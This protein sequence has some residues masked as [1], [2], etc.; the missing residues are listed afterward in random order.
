MN[1]RNQIHA[2]FVTLFLIIGLCL[3][4]VPASSVT[5]NLSELWTAS[6]SAETAGNYDEA[7]KQAVQWREAG[8]NKY[9]AALRDGW[10]N[11][12]KKDYPKA[13]ASYEEA[14]RLSTASITPLTG[15]LATAQA[16]ESPENVRAAADRILKLEPT[17]Y[18][19]LMAL[20]YSHFMEK[21]YM[22]ALSL[23]R[24]VVASYPENTDALS[25]AAWSAFYFG[26]KRDA[27]KWFQLIASIN[28]DYPWAKRGLELC[29]GSF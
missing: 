4:V 3:T 16:M 24:R 17:N 21:D 19:A 2:V 6:V 20:A 27:L 12:L 8:G 1:L 15:L 28:P 26:E 23:Y 11:Y 29:N 22:K 10:L 13:T 25:G 18:Q 9:L 5:A 14:A 7:I